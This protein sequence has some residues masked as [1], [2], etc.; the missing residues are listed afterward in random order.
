MLNEQSF[1]APVIHVVSES[2]RLEMLQARLRQAGIRPVPARGSYLPPDSAPAFVDLLTRRLDIAHDDLRLVITLGRNPE[3]ED[4]SNIHL[5]DVAQIASLRARISIR[6][7]EQQ[8]RREIKLRART[9]SL[10]GAEKP[11]QQSV[12]RERLLWLGNDAPFLNALKSTLSDGNISLVAAI[13]SLTAEDYLESGRFKTL[14]LCPSHPNDEAAKLLSRVKH[15]PLVRTPQVVLLARPD[16]SAQMDREAL[17]QADQ[18][19]DLTEDFDVVASRLRAL[20]EA[21]E[22]NEA[23]PYE[24]SSPAQDAATGLVSRDYLEKHLEAQFEQADHLAQPLSVISVDIKEDEDPKLV[25][26]KIKALLRDTDLA[27]RLDAA[28]ICV[29]LPDTAYRGGV[30]LARRIEEALNRSV[31][32]RVIERR[33]FHTLKTLLGGLTA[34]SGLSSQRIA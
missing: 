16:L 31:N 7:R 19:L 1:D 10:F 15:L 27:A 4:R 17:M 14:A 11:P 25:A 3:P 23:D 22:L 24:L 9:L 18:M 28:H 30:V 12:Q 5:T 20:S 34:R 8:R 6:Q 2:P 21:P 32:W 13:S 26:K 29:T 33:Q